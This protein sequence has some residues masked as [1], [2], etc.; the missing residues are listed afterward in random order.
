MN[1][2]EQGSTNRIDNYLKF[3][4]KIIPILFFIFG[5]SVT[6]SISLTEI[7]KALIFILFIPL[8][9]VY[10]KL[11]YK[12]VIGI[13][14]LVFVI[15]LGISVVLSKNIN[16]SVECLPRYTNLLLFPVGVIAISLYKNQ[17]KWVLYGLLIGSLIQFGIIIF[18]AVFNVFIRIDILWGIKIVK[19]SRPKGTHLYPLYYASVA[20]MVS[21]L[22]T[23]LPS[24][25]DKLKSKKAIF[26][27]LALMFSLLIF[28]GI[29]LSKT[30]GA[31]IA[32]VVAF[33]VFILLYLITFKKKKTILILVL[34]LIL[35]FSVFSF[36]LV[37]YFPETIDK[38]FSIF[39]YTDSFEGKCR[40]SIY[41]ESMKQILQK[42]I[43]GNGPL[44]FYYSCAS[45][46]S[47][48]HSHN[49]Y[50]ETAQNTGISGLLIIIIIDIIILISLIKG[51]INNH[52]N[53]YLGLIYIALLSAYIA[54]FV[55]GMT[56]YTLFGATSAP[57]LFFGM[58][59]ISKLKLCQGN[60]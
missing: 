25:I 49:N 34:S 1:I 3:L 11:F 5:F 22:V 13:L 30:R 52:N 15:F 44:T 29:V 43:F 14:L 7:S 57:L 45:Y 56:D 6:T 10:R 28:I 35:I 24:F 46:H 32:Y 20:V 9:I 31:M 12:N 51:I 4:K 17:L 58:G 21:M 41:E 60:A 50:L 54:N 37:N 23:A 19:D 39:T 26:H 36:I 40:L 38:I 8:F 59:I 16:A 48:W 55:Y 33:F 42:P 27:I 2:T 18:E 53:Y 47:A